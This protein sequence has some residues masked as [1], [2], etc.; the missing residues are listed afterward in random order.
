MRLCA[1]EA[2]S[3][4]FYYQRTRLQ[5]DLTMLKVWCGRDI[6]W[7]APNH[8]ELEQDPISTSG[9]QARLRVLYETG[10]RLLLHLRR[11]EDS[12]G[13]ELP[14]GVMICLASFTHAD[15]PWTSQISLAEA[16][17][18]LGVYVKMLKAEPGQF[19]TLLTNLLREHVKPA[20]VK[21]K[22]SAITPA[23]RKAM[24]ALPPRHEASIDETKSKP[25]KYGQVYII[26]VFEW[27]LGQLDVRLPITRHQLGC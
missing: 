20:F 7:N 11:I 9:D 27:I 4:R 17:S 10:L 1:S 13:H 5:S 6:K 16:S 18:L 23:G 3:Q 24:I 21:S 22:T 12:Y 8:I 2:I 14:A 15:D 19:Q 25:W 26:T